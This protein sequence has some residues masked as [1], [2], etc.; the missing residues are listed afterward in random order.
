MK[1]KELKLT[2]IRVVV[3]IVD[4]F[5]CFIY[6]RSRLKTF[7]YNIKTQIKTQIPKFNV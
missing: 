7:S 3:F 1:N 4:S 2:K 5:K 6:Y